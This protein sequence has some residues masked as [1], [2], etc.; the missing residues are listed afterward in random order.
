MNIELKKYLLPE[1]I[2]IID[3]Y[4]EGTIKF[5]ICLWELKVRSYQKSTKYYDKHVLHPS[6]FTKKNL[7]SRGFQFI[8]FFRTNL[9]S[10]IESHELYFPKVNIQC[11]K[12]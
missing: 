1:L 3:E 8:S 7:W 4:I 5:N 12:H 9:L 10:E 2:K 11:E 6:S